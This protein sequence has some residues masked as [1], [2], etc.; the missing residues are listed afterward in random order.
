MRP[1]PNNEQR[2]KLTIAPVL[3]VVAGLFLVVLL[4]RPQSDH[5]SNS[6]SANAAQKSTDSSSD[7]TPLADLSI[8]D[9]TK[10]RE[11]TANLP[12]AF[13]PNRAGK[14]RNLAA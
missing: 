5:V 13:E 4:Q 7:V 11:W 2:T 6:S 8:E 9:K 14:I 10:V 3:L 12:L 1:S